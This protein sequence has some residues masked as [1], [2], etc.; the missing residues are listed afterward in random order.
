LVKG[1]D[2]YIILIEGDNRQQNM[3]YKHAVSTIQPG[4]YIN[5]TNQNQN[6]NNNNNR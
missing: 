1:F 3:I 5:L 4:K 2:S 6:N